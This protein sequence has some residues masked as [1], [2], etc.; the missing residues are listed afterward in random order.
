V[1]AQPFK[2][3]LATMHTRISWQKHLLISVIISLA[4]I[5]PTYIHAMPQATIITQKSTQTLLQYQDG[6]D[7]AINKHLETKSPATK[8]L[9]DSI[10]PPNY[11]PQNAVIEF[12]NQT[13]MSEDG[14]QIFYSYKPVIG[15]KEVGL[16]FCKN[17]GHKRVF[18]GC[19]NSS[20]GIFIQEITDPR[21]V[22]WMPVTA[23]H[24][25]LHAAYYQLLDEE[26]DQLN[27]DLHQF[28]DKLKNPRIKNIIATLQS[29][30]PHRVDSEIHSLLGTEVAKL[31]PRLEKH[32]SKFFI[33]RSIVVVSF[34][35]SNQIF[36]QLVDKANAIDKKLKNMKTILDREEKTVK[37]AG[38]LIEQQRAQLEKINDPEI[39]NSKLA[40]FNQRVSN[41][42]QRIQVLKN[43]IANYNKLVNDY[44]SLS[45]EEKSLNN[46][47]I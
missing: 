4:L 46:A 28:Y 30:F 14:R 47:F 7:V 39:Y 15:T 18:I 21:L 16:D 37:I 36:D 38:K 19:F 10:A 32:Y 25:M 43:M 41:Y 27:K 20:K 35:K 31:S 6:L 24:E 9:S 42:N 26:K 22:G 45:L 12:A 2:E 34:K 23:A 33:D 29:E 8:Q 11:S 44:N 40:K 3:K 13:D 17:I 1:N 5:L